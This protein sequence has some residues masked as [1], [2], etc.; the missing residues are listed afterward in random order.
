MNHRRRASILL[1]A[2]IAL[3]VHLPSASAQSV[4][5][6]VTMNGPAEIEEVGA[7][8]VGVDTSADTTVIVQID[9]THEVTVYQNTY[10]RIGD[11]LRGD[12]LGLGVGTVRVRGSL[13]VATASAS[14]TVRD[15]E[16]T[17][18][19][20]DTSGITTIEVTDREAAVRGINDDRDQRVPA[21]QMVRVGS[22]GVATSPQVTAAGFGPDVIA[23][24]RIAPEG[25]RGSSGERALPYLVM[26]AATACLLVGVNGLMASR[27][28]RAV[29]VPV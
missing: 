8:V 17:V 12:V 1:I 20:D 10:L 29:R 18:A 27:R 21:G 7:T 5:T 4:A 28:S 22:D 9:A 3:S 26:I 19:Y 24:A 14:A 16:M 6:V 2:V 13:T 25:A 15:S 23:A 11:L